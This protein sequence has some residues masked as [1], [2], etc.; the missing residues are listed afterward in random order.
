VLVN[1]LLVG[2]VNQRN[3]KGNGGGN[4]SETPVWNELDQVVREKGGNTSL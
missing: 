3:E 2:G 1:Q 4:D